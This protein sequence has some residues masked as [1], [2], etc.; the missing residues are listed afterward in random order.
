MRVDFPR[1]E[2]RDPTGWISRAEHY[3]RYYR[4]PEDSMVDTAVNHLERDAIR[5]FDVKVTDSQ[6]LKCDQRCLRVKLLLQDQE[7]LADFFLLSLDDYE[8]MLDNKWLTTLGVPWNFFKF[9][10]KF[11]SHGKQVI[12]CGKHGSDVTTICTQRMKEVLHKV[13][14][15]FLMQLQQQSMGEPTKIEDPNLLHLLAEF[16]DVFAEPRSLPPTRRHDHQIPI[17]PRKPLANTRSYRYH[18]LQKAEIERIEDA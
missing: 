17:L 1:W 8:A 5:W 2:E 14:S 16:L 18:H 15:G 4:T 12:L 9:I 10:M 7:I 3:F 11:F 13:N 6:I